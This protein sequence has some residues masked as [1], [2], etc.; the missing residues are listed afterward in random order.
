MLIAI[1]EDSV[2]DMERNIDLCD[3][4]A[5]EK[6]YAIQTLCYAN[7]EKILADPEAKKVD[8]LLLDIIMPGPH[9]PYAA[10]IETARRFRADGFGGPII[11]MTSS[12]DYYPEGFEVGAT[13]YLL[14]P[15]DYASFEIAL[16]RAIQMIKQP[17]RMITVPVNRIHVSIAR[18]IIQYAEVFGRET[19]LYTGADK[20]RVLLPLKKIETL[21]D[22]DPFLRC[23]RSYI[24]NMDYVIS[25]DED[26]F[27]M[28]SKVR[29][30]ISL[31]S[32][33]QLKERFFAYRLAKARPDHT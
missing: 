32:K 13:H 8:L 26:H 14:K 16:D 29:I 25:L 17:E 4:Y 10:G 2:H 23:Y 27:I 18:S 30:P 1:C 6:G 5:S 28:E 12:D 22:G 7:A 11:F 15:L 3:R 20:V 21:L 19:N 9:G 24:I 31:R 33:Q